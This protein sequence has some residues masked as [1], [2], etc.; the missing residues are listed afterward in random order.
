MGKGTVVVG[1]SGGVDSSV[2]ALLLKKQGYDVTGVTMQIWLSEALYDMARSDGCCSLAAVDD[3][4]RVCDIIGIRHRVVNFRD[5]FKEKV[6]NNFVSEYLKGRTPNPCIVCNRYVK[7]ESLLSWAL[8]NGADYI[9]TGHYARIKRL[10]NGRFAV[11][12]SKTAGKDQTYAL[13][14]LTQDQLSHTLMPIGDYD[15]ETVRRIAE[16]EGLPV[17]DKPDSQEICFIEDNDYAGFIDRYPGCVIPGPGNFVSTD[18][19]VLGRHKGITRYTVGQ[20]RGLGLPMGKHVYVTKIDPERNEVVI[21]EEKDVFSD[22]LHCTGLNFM[23]EDD[24]PKG[25][26]KRLFCKIRYR[27]EGQW[28]RVTRTGEDELFAE[29]EEP[30]RAVTPGQAA[31]FYDKDV[32]FSGGTITGN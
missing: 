26:E 1:M 24:L 11:C 12:R 28:C 30:A 19:R 21:G 27:H 2:A 17:F 3:A 16:N 13:Y 23:A 15:K 32:I 9:A 25:K 5:I 22:T 14:S 18:G 7:W 29:F 10:E 8:E 31:V 4:E 20:R 6:I